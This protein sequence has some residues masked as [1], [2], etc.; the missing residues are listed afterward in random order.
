MP[1]GEKSTASVEK[2]HG[3][4]G[5]NV[6]LVLSAVDSPAGQFDRRGTS[7]RET[8]DDVRDRRLD[9][10]FDGWIGHRKKLREAPLGSSQV[11][12]AAN[13]QWFMIRVFDRWLI[14][15]H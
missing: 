12:N 8:D 9:P 2:L 13:M 7:V 1:T 10:A 6:H 5:G 4:R 15:I 14:H 3:D 11:I